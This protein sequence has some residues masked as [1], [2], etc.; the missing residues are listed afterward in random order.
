MESL[1]LDIPNNKPGAQV[2][3]PSRIKEEEEEE[4]HEVDELNHVNS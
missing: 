1:T 2:I 3:L 4:Q